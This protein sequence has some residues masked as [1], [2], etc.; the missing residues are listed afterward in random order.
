MRVTQFTLYNNFLVNHQKDLNDLTKIQTQISTG[1]KIDKIYDDP[2]VFTKYLQLNE[3]INSFDQIKNSAN[4]ALNFSRE[5]DTTMNDMVKTLTSFKTKL[6]QAANDTQDET[7]REAIVS[8][9]KGMLDHLKDLANT[10]IDGKYIFSGSAF[11]KKPINDEFEYEGNDKYVKAFLGAGVEREYNIPG[12]EVFFGRDND[13]KKHITLNI[14]QYDKL[15]ANPEFVVRGNDG[16]LYIDKTNPT[17]YEETAG[18]NEPITADSEIRSL[19]GVS[20]IKNSDGSYSAGESMFI[21]KGRDSEGNTFSKAFALSNSDKVSDLLDKIGTLYG[22]TP[23][24]KVVDVY[25]NDSGEIQ[26]KDLKT[27]KLDTNFWMAAVNAKDYDSTLSIEDNLKNIAK[28]GNYFVEFQRSD[29]NT[30]RDLSEINATNTFLDNRVFKFGA[31]FKS[32]GRD[33]VATDTLDSVFGT[34]GVVDGSDSVDNAD[35]VVLSGTATDGSAVDDVALKIDNNTTM[36][37]I[38]NTIKEKFKADAKIENGEIIVTDSTIAKNGTSQ[39]KI[40]IKTVKDDNGDGVYEKGTDTTKIETIRR[41]DT[42]NMDEIY[43]EKSANTL[44]SNTPQITRSSSYYIKDG[45][46]MLKTM[47]EVYANENTLLTDVMG[48][49]DFPKT[50]NIRYKDIKGEFKTAS[51]TINENEITFSADGKTSHVYDA[52]GNITPAFDTITTTSE[53]DPVTCQLCEKENLTK[54]F[55]Y[56]QLS[57]VVAMIVSDNIPDDNATSYEESLKKAKEVID[58]GLDDKGRLY[59]KQKNSATTDIEFSM[60]DKSSSLS[61]ES[62]NAITIDSAENDFFGTLQKAIKAVENGK[63]FAD[64]YSN[65]PRNYGIQGAL[66]AI[67]HVMDRV[68]RSHAKIGAVSNEFDMTIQRVEMLKVNVQELQSDNIDTDI[69]EASMKL[70]SIKTSYEALLASIAKVNNLTLLNYLR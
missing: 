66:E 65:D 2:I 9:L 57:D 43:F 40:N 59:V 42:L 49:F 70:N 46:K 24:K 60:F 21:V 63:N 22:N 34:K 6:L 39:L 45:K 11:D 27:G 26:I 36:Q 62:N 17:P 20:D 3:E 4:F 14:P 61:F 64:G 35:F 44:S 28:N 50:L 18:I 13:Y 58:S 67:E 32:D 48:D 7:S 15:K 16:H 69:G 52:N 56:K 12:S 33:A 53:L 8:D 5:T 47:D 54:G 29:L 68:R 55:T 51:I 30:I 37:D 1:K 25:L 10:S 38:L 41:K 19:T 23:D 31:V